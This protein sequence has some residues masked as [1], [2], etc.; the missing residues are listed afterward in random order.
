M[1]MQK[2]LLE[3]PKGLHHRLR[4]QCVTE[5]KTMSD[6]ITEALADLLEKKGGK[7]KN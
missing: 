5:G 1:D 3:L 4:I 2:V 7:S 6:L